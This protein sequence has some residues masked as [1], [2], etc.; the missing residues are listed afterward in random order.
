[1]LIQ[2]RLN[3]ADMVS[4][5]MSYV[6]G[7][8][9]Q[10]IWIRCKHEDWVNDVS[11]Q[12]LLRRKMFKFY[13]CWVCMR[14]KLKVFDIPVLTATPATIPLTQTGHY[15][16]CVGRVF[17]NDNGLFNYK[18]THLTFQTTNKLYMRQSAHVPQELNGPRQV[19][20]PSNVQKRAFR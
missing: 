1:M 18:G 13:F 8:W 10:K 3:T 6:S 4:S 12:G 19:K 11:M 17:P 5:F 7:L 20:M 15:C 9:R 16:S 2:C 14:Y